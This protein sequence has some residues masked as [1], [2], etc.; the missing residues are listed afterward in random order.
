MECNHEFIGILNGV[1]CKKCGVFLSLTDYRKQYNMQINNKNS[2]NENTQK[3]RGRK[4]VK[5]DE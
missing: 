5:T 4:K 3:P 1:R 2:S